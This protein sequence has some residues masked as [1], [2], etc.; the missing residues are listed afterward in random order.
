M[1]TLSKEKWNIILGSYPNLYGNV[2]DYTDQ[3]RAL[4]KAVTDK[5]DDPARRFLVGFHYAYLGY[6]QQAVNQ[7]D[8]CL[9][10]APHDEMA[11]Q[12]RDELQAKLHQPANSTPPALPVPQIIVSPKVTATIPSGYTLQNRSI[13]WLKD[14]QEAGRVSTQQHKAMLVLVEA[15]WCGACNKMLQETFADPAVATRINRQFVPVLIDSDQQATLVQKLNVE[16]MPTVLVIVDQRIVDRIIGFQ[17]AA[18]FDARLAA[19]VRETSGTIGGVD[20]SSMFAE[21]HR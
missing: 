6:S 13:A 1:Q 19:F 7:I 20:R 14:L 9:I 16:A 21:R 2:Q 18:Q 17:T 15:R 5:P 12:L 4:E 11:K 3:L 10:V 8:K